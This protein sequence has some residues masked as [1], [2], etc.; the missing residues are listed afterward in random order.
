MTTSLQAL[1]DL[2]LPIIQAPMAGVQNS[3]LVIAVSNAGGLG[4][5]PCAMLNLATLRAELTAIR[6]ACDKPYNV[7]FFCHTPG[8][9]DAH[10]ESVW[11]AAAEA[12][13]LGD[14]SPLWCGQNASGCR[15]IPAARLTRELAQGL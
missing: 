2:E 5:L 6:A 4:S 15:E 7:N 11:R 10:R 13:G 12:A 9:V 1:L 3:A 8:A 14:F